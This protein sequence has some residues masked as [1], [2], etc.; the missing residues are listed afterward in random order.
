MKN[1]N[2]QHRL[3]IYEKCDFK[4]CYCGLIFE[5]PVGY[6]GKK[7][8]HNGVMFLEIDHI[9]PTSKG[10]SDKLYNKQSLCQRCNN[11]KSNKI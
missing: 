5:Y 9:I 8:L 11:K 10:G 2:K 3:A 7:A 6:D 4:C 1:K